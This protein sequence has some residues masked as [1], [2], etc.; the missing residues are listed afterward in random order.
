MSFPI[1]RFLVRDFVYDEQALEAGKNE[2][3]KL[4]SDK[5]KQFV[6]SYNEFG[7]NWRVKNSKG[8]NLV[9]RDLFLSPSRKTEDP[10]Y[11]VVEVL[12]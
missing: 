6:S 9:P 1:L 8:T 7:M 12:K 2:I 11:E 3:T 4:E 10:G 5:K